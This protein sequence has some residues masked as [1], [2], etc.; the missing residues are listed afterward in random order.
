M[1]EMGRFHF[2]ECRGDPDIVSGDRT[3]LAEFS[4]RGT[5]VAAGWNSGSG[6]HRRGLSF[7]LTP[8]PF[9]PTVGGRRRR[10][11]HGACGHFR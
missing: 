4:K 10:Q 11:M 8:E 7:T 2:M 6:N 1:T 9:S 5:A 3:G